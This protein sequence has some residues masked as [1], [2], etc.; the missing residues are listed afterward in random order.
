MP[1]IVSY[2]KGCQG[3]PCYGQCSDVLA[4]QIV[5]ENT[6]K[7]T[8]EPCTNLGLIEVDVDAQQGTDCRG[9]LPVR[10][11]GFNFFWGAREMHK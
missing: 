7:F 6:P 2:L 11:C 9:K 8:C 4:S 3:G 1:F 5:N 10:L